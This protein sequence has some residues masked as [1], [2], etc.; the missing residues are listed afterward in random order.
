MTTIVVGGH[1]RNVGKT[2]VAAGLIKS[3]PEFSWTAIKIST[4]CHPGIFPHGKR[5][6]ENVCDI[7]EEEGTE[8]D[9]DTARF[10]KAGASRSL[11]IRVRR[12]SMEAARSKLLPI[13]RASSAVIIE[14]NSILRLIQPELYIIVLRYDIEDFKESA[15]ESIEQAH[16]AVA[17][18]FGK[19]PRAW[20]D[21][22]LAVLERI[23][24]F[25]STEPHTI[26]QGLRSFVRSRLQLQS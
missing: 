1:S 25:A 16:A 10:L 22:P 8:G 17:V 2:S 23:P 26:P 21:V 4:H 18:N 20:G 11:W 6:P 12:N 13:L 15:R 7:Y 19:A 14:S 9:S 5:Q 24:V 3:L